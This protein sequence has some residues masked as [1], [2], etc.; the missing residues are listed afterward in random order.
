MKNLIKYISEKLV[1]DKE[2]KV[3][4]PVEKDFSNVRDISFWP[5][6]IDI[7]KMNDYHA[8]GSKP[9]RL[10]NSIKDN[11][12]LGRRFAVAVKMG[13]QEAI[14]KF[15]KALVDRKCYTQDEIDKYISKRKK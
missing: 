8:K 13:W 9:E 10:V 7:Q 4:K 3:E 1:I 15:G 5:E 6:G 14:E 11:E 2:I 12:K